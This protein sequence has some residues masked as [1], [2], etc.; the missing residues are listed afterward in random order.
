MVI[1]VDRHHHNRHVIV[2]V[3]VVVVAVVVVAVVVVV[4]DRHAVL[5]QPILAREYLGH[6]RGIPKRGVERAAQHAG[7]EEH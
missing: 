5:R 7:V 4:V 2:V 6:A 3:V 1:V